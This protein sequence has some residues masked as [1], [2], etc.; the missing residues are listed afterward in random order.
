MASGYEINFDGIVGP[1]HH[2]GGLSY[3]NVASMEH[4]Q[5]PSNPKAAALQG[6]QKMKFLMDLGIKQAVLPPHERPHIPTLRNLGFIGSDN[7]IILAASQAIPEIFL[8]CS[9][10]SA[11]WT[12]NAATISP[13]KDSQDGHVHI[14]PANLSSKFHR[15]IEPPTTALALK[16]IFH[17]NTHFVHHPILPPGTH[18]ADEGAANH[19]RFSDRAATAGVQLFVYGRDAFKQAATPQIY[20]ARQTFEASQ[21]IVRRHQLHSDRVIIAQQNPQAIDAGVFHNDVISV[22][23]ETVFLYHTAAFVDTEAVITDIRQKVERYCKKNMVLIPVEEACISIREAVAT[24]LFN[25]QIVTLK[26]QTMAMIAPSE[27]EDTRCVK[28]F[29][30]SVVQDPQNPIGAVHYFNLKESMRNGGG[31]ACLRLRVELTEEEL[32]AANRSVFLNDEL[33]EAL[34]AWVHRHYRDRL[35]PQEM[36]DPE[37]LVESQRALDELSQLLRLGSIYSFQC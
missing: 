11:M 30:E 12:A 7:N 1:T 29:L 25:C 31:P 27:C 26:D 14:T 3:G 2:Y 4:Q 20:P 10:S 21:A 36:V 19:T 16:A 35:L 23:H 33:Y 5:L 22:G 37:L 32:A 18:F 13:S 6:L 15:S 24:Y 9:S 28:E 17:D 8:A 34:A